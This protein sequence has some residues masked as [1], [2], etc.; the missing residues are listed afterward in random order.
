MPRISTFAGTNNFY[1]VFNR[2]VDK[3]KIFLSKDD[4]LRFYR[5]LDVFNTHSPTINFKV[6]TSNKETNS[7]K[8]V[9]IHAYALLPNHYHL[10][11]E[12]ITEG[13]IGEFMKRI[14]V[15]YTGYFNDKYDR[16]G[17]L[18]QGPYKRVY[19]ATDEQYNYL[20]A[21]VNEN[22]VV[23]GFKTPKDVC[24]TSTW[25]YQNVKQSR[26]VCREKTDRYNIEEAITLAKNIYE[27]RTLMKRELFE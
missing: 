20:L 11:L 25:H 26:L 8:L 27:R 16:S 2:G 15:G 5:S 23:H 19:I 17:A 18:F 4:Y 7:E 24:Y 1:H 13:G 12:Q 14:N 9:K 6:A 10:V 21:Y 22:Y 3:R